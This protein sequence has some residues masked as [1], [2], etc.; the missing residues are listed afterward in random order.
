MV[1]D[2]SLKYL[3][4]RVLRAV[5]PVLWAIHASTPVSPL[6]RAGIPQKVGSLSNY[7]IKQS[8]LSAPC[9]DDF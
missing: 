4:G 9:T 8:L 2:A 3:A 6:A 7:G 1:P 5:D